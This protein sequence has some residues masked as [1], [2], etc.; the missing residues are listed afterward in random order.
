MPIK[1]CEVC[2][3]EFKARLTVYRT[4]GVA[5][6]NRLIS[7]EKEE[8]H[9][10][11]K[12]CQVCGKEFSNTGKQK[13]RKTCSFACG[14]VLTAKAR[15]NQVQRTCLTC[16]CEFSA[17]GSREAKYCSTKCMY[18]R[19]GTTYV[20]AVSKSGK[21]YVRIPRAAEAARNTARRALQLQATPQWATSAGILKFYEEAQ[22]LTATTGLVH[23]VD[24]KVPLNSRRVCGLHCEANLCVILGAENQAKSNRHWPDMP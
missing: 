7:A 6:R 20:Q 11:T 22:S 12:P 21:P 4:C 9:T 18:A 1:N 8:R 13:H 3:T 15:E 23:H 19:N 24:H 16:G 10:T 17:E 5:C 14:H 2:G